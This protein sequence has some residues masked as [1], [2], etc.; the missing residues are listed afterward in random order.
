MSSRT[1]QNA[2]DD[3]NSLQSNAAILEAVRAAGGGPNRFAIPEMI[4]YLGRIGYTPHDLN[5][6]NVIHITGTKGKGSTSAFT[7]SILHHARPD[8]KIGLYTSP[9]LVAVRERIRI[10]GVPLSEND[11]TRYF[12][13]VWDRLQ[14]NTVRRFESTSL[15]PNYFRFLTLLAFHT[16][17]CENVNA[18]ILEVGVGGT[19][20][21]T[22]I[23]P[24]PVV[25]GVTALGLDHVHILG[26]TLQEIAWQKGGIYKEGV[27]AFTMEQRDGAIEVLRQR[28]TELKASEF[29]I[30]PLN[31]AISNVKLGLSGAHQYQNATLA[32]ALARAFLHR[33]TNIDAKLSESYTKGLENT[34]WP[35]RC[36]TV[37]DPHLQHTTWYLDGAHT[38][39]S[40]ECC[41]QW[42]ASRDVGL[43]NPDESNGSR[44]LIFNCTQGRSGASLLKI[45]LETVSKQLSTFEENGSSDTFFDHVVFCTN[46]T[47][48]DGHSK[49]DLKAI[50]APQGTLEVQHQLA[51]SW[52]SLVPSFPSSHV[53]VLPTVEDAI[54]LVRS[55][56]A[57]SKVPVKVLVTGSLH[58][59]GGVIEA[60]GIAECAL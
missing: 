27:P 46:I 16:L 8:L 56:E 52:S 10:N 35:G 29:S 47:Y 7:N 22:N 31:P 6:L 3:L 34:R 24:R 54:Q 21:S 60:A 33:D 43:F 14:E 28:A 37:I 4:E 45:I 58:L 12:Y 23:V 48:A 15:M 26:K 38:S 50:A 55:V 32:I 42:F 19:Y 39:E 25:T 59:V 9:H 30:V 11:F 57:R 40:I 17:L 41:L 5:R 20:D 49:G 51:S 44:A 13:E 18:T 1:Y 53:H 2:I 36:Q